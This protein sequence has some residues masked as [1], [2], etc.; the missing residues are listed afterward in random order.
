M[1]QRKADNYDGINEEN[2]S[3]GECVR[4]DGYGNVQ[5]EGTAPLGDRYQW[6]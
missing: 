6:G 4:Y 2:V 1:L 5:R 3:F